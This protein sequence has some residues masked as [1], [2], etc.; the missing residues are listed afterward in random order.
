MLKN[1][2][3][4]ETPKGIYPKGYFDPCPTA[5]QIDGLKIRWH[6]NTFCN[7]PYSQLDLWVDKAIKEY[8]RKIHCDIQLLVPN[9]TD[10]KW[11]AKLN[12]LKPQYTFFTGRLKFIDPATKQPGRYNPRFGSILVKL[13]K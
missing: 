11:F 7:P 8:D 13:Q 5:P 12:K 9:W 1:S 4:W 10:R 3:F 6:R 2:D